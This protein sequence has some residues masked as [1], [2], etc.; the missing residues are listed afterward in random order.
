[1][2]RAL[3]IG[4]NGF[5]RIGRA[6]VR[7]AAEHS[8]VTVAVVN[9]LDADIHNL[10][11]LLKYDSIYGRFSRTVEATADPPGL[12]IGGQLVPFY[13]R[14]DIRE[15]PWKAAGVDVVIEA[16]GVD[17]NGAAAHDLV[18]SG[19]PKVVITNAHRQADATVIMGV[20]E[21][22]YDRVRHHVLSSSICD[23][24][25]IAPV[26]SE[27]DR[28]WGV[29]SCFVT[30][31]HP[32]LSYQNLL[33][34]TINSVA[35]PGHNWKDYSLGRSS[36][37]SLIAKDTTAARATLA[38]LPALEGRIDAISFRVPTAIVSASDLCAVLATDVTAAEVNAHFAAQAQR[39]PDVFGYEEDH[40]V[41]IDYLGT[42]TSFVLDAR[43]T[44]VLRSRLI[45]LVVWYDN[46]W[47]YSCR[48]LD[49]ARLTAGIPSGR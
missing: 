21:D 11:Y 23:A 25:A 37:L 49:V 36:V 8:D 28:T 7:I 34:G 15:V 45:K 13:S 47:G 39:R 4:V 24:N 10:A 29:E 43:R 1:M 6:V 30:T 22:C 12:R 32:W 9:E 38:V 2:S 27:L 14:P 35:S 42:R 3:R 20:N 44:R 18:A 41:S 33:D 17:A 19:V 31:L 40:L 26:V 5:G 16:S 46:E 48:V